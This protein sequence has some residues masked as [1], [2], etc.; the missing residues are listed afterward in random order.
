MFFLYFAAL[1]KVDPCHWGP[2]ANAQLIICV[3][4][5]WESDYSKQPKCFEP[6]AIT[7]SSSWTALQRHN[8]RPHYKRSEE[9]SEYRLLSRNC[10][11]GSS[12]TPKLQSQRRI[13][14]IVVYFMSGREYPKMILTWSQDSEDLLIKMSTPESC[15]MQVFLRIYYD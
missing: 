11:S 4:V 7:T 12:L 15:Q 13:F 2:N 9:K 3:Q 14:T 10:A 5:R 8:H 1:C 6:L